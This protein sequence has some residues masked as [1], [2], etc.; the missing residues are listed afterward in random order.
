M[1]G[2]EI[3]NTIYEYGSLISEVY[4][5]LFTGAALILAIIGGLTTSYDAVQKILA[6]LAMFA[7]IGMIV[8]FIGSLIDTEEIIGTKYQVVISEEVKFNEFV[9]R[10]EIISQDG[11]IYTVKERKGSE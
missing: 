5:I 10:Y 11:K 4:A 6:T 2:V 3:L 9:E 1:N 8:S 7:V